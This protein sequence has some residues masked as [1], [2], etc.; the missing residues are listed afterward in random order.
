VTDLLLHACTARG[1]ALRLK[2]S[3]CDETARVL[4]EYAEKCEKD[5]RDEAQRALLS[6]FSGNIRL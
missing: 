2:L 6:N 3:G 1:T 5:V 4:E